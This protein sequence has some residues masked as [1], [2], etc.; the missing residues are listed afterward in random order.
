MPWAELHAHSSYSF[1][2]G[3]SDPDALVA[4]AARLGLD[5]SMSHSC[6]D[7]APDGAACGQCDACRLRAKGF[8]AVSVFPDT[9]PA[10]AKP[11]SALVIEHAGDAGVAI[12][13]DPEEA[14]ARMGLVFQS[15]ALFD[16]LNVKAEYVKAFWNIVNWQDAAIA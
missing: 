8:E 5:A 3:A 15:S 16:Y 4:E 6:Y 7:P 10:Y 13:E 2:D 12:A 9:A 1:L 14:R 11:L